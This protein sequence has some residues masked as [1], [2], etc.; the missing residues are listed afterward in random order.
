MIR[1]RLATV[2]VA[3]L[4]AVIAG[5]CAT[6][7]PT[8]A[9]PPPPTA[10]PTTPPTETTAPAISGEVVFNS[11]GGVVNEILR[12]CFLDPFEQDTGVTVIDTAPTDF[13]KLQVMVQSGNVEWD[14]TEIGTGQDYIRAV[15]MELLENFGRGTLPHLEDAVEGSV[16]DYGIRFGA[17]STVLTYRTDE[18]EVAPSTWADLFD[19]EGYPGPRSLENTP[20]GNLEIALL[21]DGVP[22]D[23][24]YPLDVDRAF[25]KLDEIKPQV[26]AYWETGA[27]S[28]QL[29]ADGESVMGT[30][31]NG[32]VY[33]MAAEGIPIALSW[34]Q[35]LLKTAWITVPK[36]APNLPAAIE[37]MKSLMDPERQ[38]CWNSI[39]PYP[40]NNVKAFDYVPEDLWETMPTSPGNIEK[41]V[42]VDDEWWAE[43]IEDLTRRW[44]EWIQE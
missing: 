33:A 38:G 35:H 40:G 7:T 29:L 37:L 3:A 10:Q 6:V 9:P 14:I 4:L 13:A 44:S 32:R 26:Q 24:L 22:A 42:I 41:A 36:G 19:T 23:A 12:Q 43:N 11:S 39:I 34:E 28:V 18:F 25:A 20:F 8:A 5:G 27:E 21:A 1:N 31:W 15:E 2:L 30:S 17:Y 16:T